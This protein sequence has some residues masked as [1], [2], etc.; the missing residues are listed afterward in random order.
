MWWRHEILFCHHFV[1]IDFVNK[2]QLTGV[3]EMFFFRSAIYMSASNP[4]KDGRSTLKSGMWKY[5]EYAVTSCVIDDVT[6]HFD[7]A[8]F[9]DDFTFYFDDFTFC[10]D[11]VRLRFNE[12]SLNFRF[13][14]MMIRQ[15]NIQQYSGRGLLTQ[16]TSTEQ[17]SYTCWHTTL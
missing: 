5:C 7:D 14:M 10:F 15:P 11:Y 6:L 16:Q 1:M 9:F 4:M 13:L 12:I 2:Y 8:T 3:V 17:L